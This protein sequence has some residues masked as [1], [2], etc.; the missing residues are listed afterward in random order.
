MSD[1][2]LDDL[3]FL[4][5]RFRGVLDLIPKFEKIT[6]LE[7]YLVE[8]EKRKG[9]IQSEVHEEELVLD[10]LKTDKDLAKKEAAKIIV[11]AKEEVSRVVS[12]AKTEAHG[13]LVSANEEAS[14]IIQTAEKAAE[15]LNQSITEKKNAIGALDVE[16]SKK[17]DAVDYLKSELSRLKSKL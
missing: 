11:V 15:V 6:S 10:S 12:I 3:R 17:Q 2:A 4:E 16:I 9:N 1:S 13:I 14:K 5:K 7:N 8:L